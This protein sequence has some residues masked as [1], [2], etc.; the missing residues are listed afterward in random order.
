MSATISDAFLLSSFSSRPRSTSGQSSSRHVQLTHNF[1]GKT[2]GLVAVAVQGDGVHVLDLSTLHPTISHTLGP[3]TTFSCPPVTRT[4]SDNGVKVFTTLVAVHSSPDVLPEDRER[5]VWMWEE[6]LSGGAVSAKA[7]KKKKSAVLPHPVRHIYA[8]DDLPDHVLLVGPRGEL[9]VAD[10][11]LAVHGSSTPSG[12]SEGATV[13]LKVIFFLRT[14]CTFVPSRTAASRGIVSVTFLRDQDSIRVLVRVVDPEGTVHSAGDC[15]IPLREPDEEVCDVSC[16]ASGCLSVLTRM[17]AWY[18]FQLESP[19]NIALSLRILTNLLT[20][21][22]LSFIYPPSTPASPTTLEISLAALNSSHVLLAGIS[23]TG[24]PELVLLLWDL[25]YSVLIASHTFA[26]PSTLVRTKRRG[27][28]IDLVASESQGPAQALLVLS[29]ERN[30]LGQGFS[31]RS[32]CSTVLVVPFSV[33]VT[34]TIANA[35]GRASAGAA[36]VI[37]K[38]E[39]GKL[40]TKSVDP[41]QGGAVVAM[42]TASNQQRTKG[43]EEAFFAW[44]REEEA[45]LAQVQAQTREEEGKPPLGHLFVTRVLEFVFRHLEGYVPRVLRYLLERGAVSS[46][47]VAGG[48]FP[49][50]NARQDWQSAMLALRTVTDIPEDDMIALLSKVVQSHEQSVSAGEDAM[51]I[52]SVVPANTAGLPALPTYLALCVT[53]STSPAALR[54]ALRRHLSDA[55]DLVPVLAVLDGWLARW[56]K[57]E[58]HLLPDCIKKDAHGVL[59]PLYSAHEPADLPPQDKVLAFLQTLLDA[60]F[61]ALLAHPPAHRLLHTLLARLQPELALLDEIEQL[62]VPLQPFAAAH[63][64]ALYEGA[65]GPPK[66]DTRVDWRRRKKMAHEQAELALGL[67]Q[68]EELVI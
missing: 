1:S 42:N 60:S 54:V 20:L 48:L 38:R 36:W 14:A 64:R 66:T 41:A 34:S 59:V 19:N 39:R 47:M 53:Y 68:V 67:Y 58:V 21:K 25:Q 6:T 7:Q 62:R 8:S 52:D 30:A 45:Q 32:A 15:L 29:P 31:G 24:A 55:A 12:S 49:A 50:L 57:E 40:L 43:V 3:S 13:L 10:T 2:D 56:G 28:S 61:L 33:P 22:S 23:A 27:I 26:L 4:R 17:G 37:S 11:Q 51:Q 65:H 46:V 18:S 35:L 63:A 5:T 9:T 44:V 16:S